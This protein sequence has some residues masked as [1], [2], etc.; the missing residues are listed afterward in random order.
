[1]KHRETDDTAVRMVIERHG[2][3]I[4]VDDAHSFDAFREPTCQ[5]D[6]NLKC[7]QAYDTVRQKTSGHAIS[8]TN[9]KYL[10]PEVDGIHHPRHQTSLGM[11]SPDS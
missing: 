4:P 3:A 8:R 11:A 10:R 6:V 9:L 2:C 5:I 1:M 7:G